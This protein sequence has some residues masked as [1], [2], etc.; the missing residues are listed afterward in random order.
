[1]SALN[2]RIKHAEGDLCAEVQSNGGGAFDE[3]LEWYVDAAWIEDAEA[4]KV[5]DLTD[6]EIQELDDGKNDAFN[7]A[8]GEAYDEW[9][10]HYDPTP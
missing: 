6:A 9:A 10:D 3:P 5:R 1:M 8:V 7:I 4:K 2:V